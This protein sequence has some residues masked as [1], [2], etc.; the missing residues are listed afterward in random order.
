MDVIDIIRKFEAEEETEVLIFNPLSY[1][2]EWKF[3]SI[4]QENIP[5]KEN[6]KLKP[7]LARVAG[8]LLVDLYVSD[9]PKGYDREKARK[10]VFP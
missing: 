7:S 3:D 9:K 1:D 8:N 5:S 6:V 4:D 10:L 2:V